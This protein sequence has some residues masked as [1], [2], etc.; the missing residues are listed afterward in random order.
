MFGGERMQW[1]RSKK[2]EVAQKN[3]SQDNQ[4]FYCRK[5]AL[6]CLIGTCV[7]RFLFPK[8]VQSDNFRLFTTHKLNS[9]QIIRPF[10]F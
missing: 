1:I 7:H 4:I 2:V 9:E 6:D 3:W 8:V 10:N 5:S